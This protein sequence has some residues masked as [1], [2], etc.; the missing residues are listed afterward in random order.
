M[1]AVEERFDKRLFVDDDFSK[2]LDAYIMAEDS[3]E[4]SS[5]RNSTTNRKVI[6]TDKT[7]SDDM[8]R[9]LNELL[10]GIEKGQLK[11][12]N[13]ETKSQAHS[14]DSVC[15]EGSEVTKDDRSERPRGKCEAEDMDVFILPESGSQVKSPHSVTEG[16]MSSDND[17]D[18]EYE[19]TEDQKRASH[20]LEQLIAETE[21]FPDEEPPEY[22][23]KDRIKQLNADLASEPMPDEREHKVMFKEDPVDLVVPPAEW[24]EDPSAEEEPSQTQLHSQTDKP[25]DNS[26]ATLNNNSSSDSPQGQSKHKVLIER[27]GKFELVSAD[28]IRARDLGMQMQFNDVSS[29]Q[30]EKREE[31]TPSSTVQTDEP[32]KESSVIVSPR[33]PS[34]PRPS[35]GH[36]GGHRGVRPASQRPHS[37][38]VIEHG[39]ALRIS[40]VSPYGLTEQEKQQLQEGIKRKESRERNMKAKKKEEDRL[41]RKENE[42]A[43]D[44]WLKRK[45]N[46]ACKIRTNSQETKREESNQRSYFRE[47]LQVKKEQNK[48]EKLLKQREEEERRCSQPCRSQKECDQ[49]FRQWL[50]KKNHDAWHRRGLE[51]QKYGMLSSAKR[52]HKPLTPLQL[53]N[54]YRLLTYHTY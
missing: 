33:P 1:N 13:G 43:F 52:L 21:G 34:A 30:R 26:Q 27:D 25:S 35:S 4:K 47:W 44:A 42:E 18:H 7:N 10:E 45:Q 29:V 32:D 46:S 37:A 39:S 14:G 31:I 2:E 5:D 22:D 3:S 23:V 49:A 15:S 54:F 38:N 51:R 50:R 48:R 6:M 36:P 19:L 8:D 28:D 16:D 53:A 24:E 41:K 9:D 12:N 11:V 20:E 40:Y 17:D